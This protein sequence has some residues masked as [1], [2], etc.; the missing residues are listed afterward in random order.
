MNS[1][2]YSS[3]LNKDSLHFASFSYP[4]STSKF[5]HRNAN[6]LNEYFDNRTLTH[7]CLE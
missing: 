7:L 3:S 1:D 4:P 6:F 2:F 5:I